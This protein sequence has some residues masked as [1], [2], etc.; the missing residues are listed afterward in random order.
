MVSTVN[1]KMTC[2]LR[3][4]LYSNFSSIPPGSFI[5]KESP[6]SQ[7]AFC[8][9]ISLATLNLKCFL[10][11]FIVSHELDFFEGSVTVAGCLQSWVCLM[12]HHDDIHIMHFDRN[13]PEV[14]LCPS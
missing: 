10:S 2:N 13:T 3:Q 11:A 5:A 7:I 1:Q 4:K 14:M 6:E 12:V 9:H 8:C